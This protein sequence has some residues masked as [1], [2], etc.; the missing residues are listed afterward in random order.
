MGWFRRRCYFLELT[1][2]IKALSHLG[3]EVFS[4][5]FFKVVTK[6][7]LGLSATIKRK[8]GLTKVI[9]WF[10]GDVFKIREG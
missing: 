6:Y 2:R 7:A 1:A 4:R 9:K 8:D 3:A 5:A 10:L